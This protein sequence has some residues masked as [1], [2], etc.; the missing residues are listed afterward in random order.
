MIFSQAAGL[1]TL[2]LYFYKTLLE[3]WSNLIHPLNKTEEKN[4]HPKLTLRSHKQGILSPIRNW[5]VPSTKEQNQKGCLE[6][7]LFQVHI[8][9]VHSCQQ[10]ETFLR[11]NTV[12]QILLYNI[13]TTGL[14]I[15]TCLLPSYSLWDTKGKNLSLSGPWLHH[16]FVG[17][18]SLS[19]YCSQLYYSLALNL[20]DN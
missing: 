14:R 15:I 3:C 5:M 11:I 19:F 8:V 4:L 13:K 6:A 1:C 18:S 17:V 9:W 16:L 2:N 10:L 20:S 7:N 12:R